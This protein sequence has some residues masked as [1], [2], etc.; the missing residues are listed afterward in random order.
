LR[1]AFAVKLLWGICLIFASDN[2]N[3]ISY[4]MFY[5]LSILIMNSG[6]NW[7]LAA[8]LTCGTTMVLTS[9]SSTNDNPA[10]VNP[11]GETAKALDYYYIK[12]NAAT[13][14]AAYKK[15]MEQ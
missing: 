3:R 6:L 5:K 1:Q 13:R 2:D 11:G 4:N 14:V 8:I 10:P 12:A 15:K 7:M 9:C